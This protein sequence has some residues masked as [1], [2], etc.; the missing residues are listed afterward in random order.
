MINSRPITYIYDD[1]SEPSPLTPAHFLIGKR[2]LS[3]PVTRVSREDF[4]GSRPSLLKRYRHQLNL[5]NQFWNRW[6]KLY[7]LSLR[8]MN[9]CPPYK[10]TCQ[11]KVDDVVL[12]HDD[13]FPRN[14]WSMEM[15]SSE[16]LNTTFGCNETLPF[17]MK[18]LPEFVLKKLTEELKE[19]PETR[20]KN[21]LELRNML[22]DDQ[23]TSGIEFEEDFLIQFLRHSKHDTGKAFYYVRNIFR[24]RKKYPRSLD[25]LPDEYFLTK[26]STKTIL[27]LP[28]RCPEGC[29]VV[30]FRYGLF[31]PKEISVEEFQR[32]VMVMYLQ[33]LRDPMTQINGFKFI[34]DFKGSN[35]QQLRTCTPQN[36]YLLYHKSL[37]CVPGR[38]K[39]FH[40]INQSIIVKPCWAM[41]RPW[42]SEKLRNRVYFHS[43]VEEL[44]NYF[45]RSILPV[46]YGGDI[47]ENIEEDWLRKAN[48]EHEN[49]GVTGQPNNF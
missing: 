47:K 41:F 43:N 38:Y 10:V 42:L 27:L 36:L 3:L 40:I 30:I 33:L 14:L 22:R 46:E 39:G 18:H 17:K 34:Y 24:L 12:I 19:T 5:L 15:S 49:Y 7:L 26:E 45:P 28:K 25:S 44:L 20:L 48:K 11:F 16:A 1:P 29:T 2:L 23:L 21:L 4:T 6:R 32:M 9:I 35:L 8:F 37:Q 31:N 13:R